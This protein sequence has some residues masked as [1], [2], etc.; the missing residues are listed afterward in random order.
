MI[1]KISDPRLFFRHSS[2][3]VK[4]GKKWYRW[5][6]CSHHEILFFLP[7]GL[8]MWL[9]PSFSLTRSNTV[10]EAVESDGRKRY[11]YSNMSQKIFSNSSCGMK[12]STRCS[13]SLAELVNYTWHHF[14]PNTW[15]YTVSHWDEHTGEDI[16]INR[17]QNW[18]IICSEN[19]S[20]PLGTDVS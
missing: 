4:L 13:Q 8:K 10:W 2:L 6:K 12:M 16:Y 3:L 18:K 11:N 19:K 7:Q 14:F 20:F 1:W 15:Q 17:L 9:F 5:E